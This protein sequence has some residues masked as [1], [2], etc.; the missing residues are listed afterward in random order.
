MSANEKS[1]TDEGGGQLSVER[2][3]ELAVENAAR[4]RR[5]GSRQWAW[6]LVGFLMSQFEH[7]V[8]REREECAGI[9]RRLAGE[10]EKQGYGQATAYAWRIANEIEERGGE[11][12]AVVRVEGGRVVEGGKLMR[13]AMEAHRVVRA[14]IDGEPHMVMALSFDEGT[15]RLVQFG[16]FDVDVLPLDEAVRCFLEGVDA[17]RE[18]RQFHEGPYAKSGD[19]VSEED[20][21]RGYEWRRGWNEAA[22]GR[23]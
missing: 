16:G 8:R 19:D 15:Y 12:G 10:M 14:W 13:E 23:A 18:G 11:G 9:A 3:I 2:R 20:Y 17:H 6:A 21:Q 4:G 1:P 5:V 7:A 22:L